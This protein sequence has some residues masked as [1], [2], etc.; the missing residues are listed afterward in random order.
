MLSTN[1]NTGE[2]FPTM[3]RGLD[4]R[5]TPPV[6]LLPPL[7]HPHGSSATPASPSVPFI[8]ARFV[9]IWTSP[10]GSLAWTPPFLGT[11]SALTS[12]MCVTEED[13]SPGRVCLETRFFLYSV[14]HSFTFHAYISLYFFFNACFCVSI[15]PKSPRGQASCLAFYN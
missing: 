8:R 12:G 15:G 7:P 6:P 2:N 14:H 4:F 3:E 5:T 11:A 1:P 13:P 9:H 10:D